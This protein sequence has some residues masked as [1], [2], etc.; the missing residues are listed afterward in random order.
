MSKHSSS[1]GQKIITKKKK[2]AN[3]TKPN[4]C[5]LIFING[6]EF[7]TREKTKQNKRWSVQALIFINKSQFFLSTTAWFER[8]RIA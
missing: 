7:L 6:S 5:S 8:E 1:W 3:Q 2:K 4:M